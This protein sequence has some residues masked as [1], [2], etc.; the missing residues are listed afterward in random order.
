MT[1]M[2]N[3]LPLVLTIDFGTQSLRTALINNNGEIEAIV[4][5]KYEP[6]YISTD[7]G[8]AEQDPDFYY[9][10]LVICLK[11]LAKENKDKLDR[12]V[13]STIATFRDSSVQLDKD[14]KPVID[15]FKQNYEIY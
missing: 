6:A 2:N 5:R 13:G 3:K 11:E 9:D 1:I 8:Y 7:K 14:F 12:I 15:F 4:K 10:N